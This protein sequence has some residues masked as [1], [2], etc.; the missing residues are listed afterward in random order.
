M[1]IRPCQLPIPNRRDF[2]HD[3]DLASGERKIPQSGLVKTFST[4][5]SI[6]LNL[7][8]WDEGHNNRVD[9]THHSSRM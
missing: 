2:Y 4:S 1:N 8:L 9:L 5:Q 3:D 6:E 7:V